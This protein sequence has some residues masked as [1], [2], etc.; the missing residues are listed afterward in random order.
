MRYN[1]CVKCGGAVVQV[2]KEKFRCTKCGYMMYINP[3]PTTAGIIM[4]GSKI[5]FV[6]RGKEP[7]KNWWDLPGGFLKEKETPEQC[8]I[9]EMKEET[10]LIVKPMK[11]LGFKNDQYHDE[12]VLGTFFLC[13]IVGGKERAGSDASEIRWFD[14]KAV[15]RNVAFRGIRVGL[16]EFVGARFT[17][18]VVK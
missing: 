17:K 16:K 10:G 4:K 11:F 9:R 7:Y 6:R 3:M 15:P 18:R 12:R 8:M 2:T 5:M 14:K 1:F 13:K